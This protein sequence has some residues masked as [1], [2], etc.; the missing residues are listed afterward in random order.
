[1]ILKNA[2]TIDVEDYYQVEA[3]S[4]L[5]DR[6]EWG[7]FESRV[8]SNTHKIMDL[9]DEYDIKGTFFILGC[10]A[11]KIPKIVKDIAARG[12]EIASHGMSH[13]LIYNQS[14]EEFKK[15]T[16]DSKALIEDLCQHSIKGYRAATYSITKESLWALD[17]IAEAGFSY[18]SSIFPM[19]HDRYGI[20]DAIAIPNKMVTPAGYSLVEFPISTVK[21]KL[22]TLPIAGGGYFRLFP[23]WLTKMGLNYINQKGQEFLFYLHPWEVDPHQPRIPNVSALTKFRHYVNIDQSENRLNKLF[24]DFQFTTMRNVLESKGLLSDGDI[25]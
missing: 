19:R 4:Q 20:Y 3:F 12:H 8:E 10:V 9:L 2:F 11:K 22:L 25:V 13:R 18:D 17:V 23:Y 6:S 24:S 5:I 1:M 16:I 15:E 21:N 14:Y 7:G